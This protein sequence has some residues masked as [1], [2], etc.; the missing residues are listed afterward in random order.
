MNTPKLDRPRPESQ[1]L[2]VNFYAHDS[3]SDLENS[4]HSSAQ[5]AYSQ[6]IRG[7]PLDRKH[8]AGAGSYR[9]TPLSPALSV[10]VEEGPP[11][12]FTPTAKNVGM[13]S[14]RSMSHQHRVVSLP[15]KLLA[16]EG[17][18]SSPEVQ[19]TPSPWP[20]TETEISAN[21]RPTGEEHGRRWRMIQWGLL[22]V[23]LFALV[24]VGLVLGL[25]F[26]LRG[27]HRA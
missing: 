19:L 23:G 1:I 8:S 2:P 15:P 9:S 6:H 14:P 3:R 25:Y 4:L 16:R 18:V 5:S 24:T 11:G 12:K 13:R 22:L 20:R 21:L 17:E 26:G 10:A 7:A 27:D